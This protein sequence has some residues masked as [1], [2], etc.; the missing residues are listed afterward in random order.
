MA[1][2]DRIRRGLLKIKPHPR[3]NQDLLS[4]RYQ[5]NSKGQKEILSKEKMRKN[6]LKSPDFADA[7]M[8]A[9]AECDYTETPAFNKKNLPRLADSEAQLM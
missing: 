5:F 2:K 7:L 6:D 3:Q 1:L 8:M 9:I 4:I